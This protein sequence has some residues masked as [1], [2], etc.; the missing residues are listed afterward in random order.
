MSDSGNLVKLASKFLGQ[1]V[2]AA[3]VFHRSDSSAAIESLP[4]TGQAAQGSNTGQGSEE[5]DENPQAER[6]L[7]AV[8]GQSVYLLSL[9]LFSGSQLGQVL[10]TFDRAHTKARFFRLDAAYRLDLQEGDRQ[11]S[12]IG[13]KPGDRPVLRALGLLS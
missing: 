8:S 4:L 7:V 13:A 1:P 5:S 3:G 11:V 10:M 6:L 2:I 9:P 12:L